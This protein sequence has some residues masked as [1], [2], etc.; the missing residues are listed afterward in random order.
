MQVATQR[1]RVIYAGSKISR[2]WSRMNRTRRCHSVA[3]EL[4]HGST[5]GMDPRSA[6]SIASAASRR[7]VG[8]IAA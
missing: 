8:T 3:T 5:V 2:H 1:P 7:R 4:P 6:R